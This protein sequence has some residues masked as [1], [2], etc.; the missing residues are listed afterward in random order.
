MDRPERQRTL[1]AALAWSWD[2]L[3]APERAALA[4]AVAIGGPAPL[5]AVAAALG[6]PDAAAHLERL[7]A[8]SMLAPARPDGTRG[9]WLDAWAGVRDFVDAQDADV[10]GAVARY[11]RWLVDRCGALVTAAQG[12]ERKTALD[13]LS[14]HAPALTACLTR[15]AWSEPQLAADALRCLANAPVIPDSWLIDTATEGLEHALADGVRATLLE[16]RGRALRFVGEIA[17]AADDLTRAYELAPSSRCRSELGTTL[18]VAGRATEALPV[19]VEHL[20]EAVAARD[21]VAQCDARTDL[22]LLAL[23]GHGTDADLHL[24][25]AEDLA[26]AIGDPVRLARTLL[27]R[28]YQHLHASAAAPAEACVREAIAILE[29]LDDPLNLSRSLLQLSSVLR[30]VPRLDEAERV[31]RRALGLALETGDIKTEAMCR[32]A[33][34][35]HALTRETPQLVEAEAQIRR[36]INLFDRLGATVQ[37]GWSWGRLADVALRQGRADAAEEALARGR[38][39]FEEAGHP[40]E[41]FALETAR[42]RVELLRARQAQR[43]G[44]EV[45]VAQLLA[46]ARNRL[47]RAEADPSME[48]AEL[49]IIATEVREE[50]AAFDAP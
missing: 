16:V 24:G 2:L 34:T 22:G 28:A 32:A 30:A 39:V 31:S 18:R 26:R 13:T 38:R 50:L 20:E 36:S 4:A 8:R 33:L 5:D 14:A 19:V 43:S 40:K 42:A 47:Q 1:R 12:R 11:D 37:T 10:G 6:G 15:A 27:S 44:R 25:A 9:A 3:S 49:A 46:V 45:E 7:C 21:L 41:A 48:S 29:P 35:F 23:R 17:R